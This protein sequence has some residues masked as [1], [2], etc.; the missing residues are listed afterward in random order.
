[1]TPRRWHNDVIL[2][3]YPER[4]HSAVVAALEHGREVRVNRHGQVVLP[5]GAGERTGPVDAAGRRQGG[6]AVHVMGLA[7]GDGGRRGLVLGLLVDQVW[8]ETEITWESLHVKPE[9]GA[10]ASQDLASTPTPTP[11]S[12]RESWSYCLCHTT[13]AEPPC[14]RRNYLPWHPKP[15]TCQYPLHETLSVRML[16]S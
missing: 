13:P 2:K 10:V 8:R 7:R 9:R 16:R 5:H 3:I 1:M 14:Q 4:S 12:R 11:P 6:R 15:L